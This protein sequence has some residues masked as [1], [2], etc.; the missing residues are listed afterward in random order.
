VL[1]WV[2]AAAVVSAVFSRLDGCGVDQPDSRPQVARVVDGDTLDLASGV[3]VRLLGLD[4]AEQGECFSAEATARLAELVPA[5][6]PVEVDP[7]GHDRYG[8]TLAWLSLPDGRDLS[9]VMVGEGMGPV[10]RTA[11]GGYGDASSLELVDVLAAEDAARSSGA[12][13]WSA[14][15]W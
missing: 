9:A 13:G 4:T 8:R 1:R 3:T 12:G 11:D 7:V 2:I 10:Y 15:G 5:G 14:C 6:T